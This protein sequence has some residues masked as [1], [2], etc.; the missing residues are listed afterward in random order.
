MLVGELCDDSECLI[1]VLGGQ[2]TS[3]EVGLRFLGVDPLGLYRQRI[4]PRSYV[5]FVS[6]Y[7]EWDVRVIRSS[8]ERIFPLY[9]PFVAVSPR[10]IVDQH[11]AVCTP[12][13]GHAQRLEAFLAR[14]VPQL[15]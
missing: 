12:I 3:L 1:N 5:Q 11:A 15:Q 10:D 6:D 14:S 9:K 8:L 13:E 7:Y 4:D 2:R